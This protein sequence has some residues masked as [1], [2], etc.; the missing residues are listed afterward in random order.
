MTERPTLKPI[1]GLKPGD[2]ASIL[3]PPP[4]RPVATAQPTAEPATSSDKSSAPDAGE[5]PGTKQARKSATRSR[6]KVSDSADV[7]RN[8]PVFLPV[9]L[10]KRFRTAARELQVSQVNLMLDALVSNKEQLEQLVK[11]DQPNAKT[12]EL[13]ARAAPREADVVSAT[14]TLRTVSSNVDTIDQL[15]EKAGAKSRSQLLRLALAAHLDKLD[16]ADNGNRV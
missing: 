13:F 1:S 6:P 8:F 3:P 5:D 14:L 9:D 12:D 15:A 16:N 2:R 11:A 7:S 10:A 4:P